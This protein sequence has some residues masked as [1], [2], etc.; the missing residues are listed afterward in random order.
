MMFEGTIRL[1][2]AWTIWLLPLRQ[3]FGFAEELTINLLNTRP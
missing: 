2:R 3:Y 1:E